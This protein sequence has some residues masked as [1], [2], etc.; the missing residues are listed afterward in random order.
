MDIKAEIYSIIE[1][2]DKT[3]VFTSETIARNTLLSYIK[4]NKGKAVFKDRFISFDHFA[5]SL[6]D[7]KGLRRVSETERRAFVSSFLK[8][9]GLGYLSYFANSKY[10]ESFASFTRYISRILPYFPDTEKENLSFLDRQMV[11][12]IEK[13]RP[14]YQEYLKERG[15]YEENYLEKDLDRIEENKIVFVYPESFTSSFCPVV[16]KSGKV[17]VINMPPNPKPLPLHEYKN[18]IS[19]IR[20]VMRKIEKDLKE[21]SP[22]EI[23]ITSSSL[24]TYRPYME[25]EAKKRDIPLLFTSSLPLSSYPEGKILS[26]FMEL[27][28]NNWNLET[29]KRLVSDPSFPFKER[30]TLIQILHFGIDMKLEGG[31]FSNWISA[32]NREKD[33]KKYGDINKAKELFIS[34]HKSINSIVKAS[35]SLDTEFRIRNF[36]SIFLSEGE[37]NEKDDRILGSIFEILEGLKELEDKEIYKIFLSILKDTFYVENSDDKGRIKVYS[38]PA[39]AGLY[40][41][42]H[43]IMGLDDK[44]TSLLVDDYPFSSSPD[45]PE[46]LDT[47]KSFLSLYSN[48]SFSDSY[49]SGTTEGYEGSRLLPTLFLDS[50]VKEEIIESDSYEREMS[51]KGEEIKCTLSQKESHENAKKTVFKEREDLVKIQDITSSERSYSVSE[52]KSWDNCPYKGYAQSIL[53]LK[54]MEYQCEMEDHFEKGNILHETIE[55]S[56]EEKKRLIDIDLETLKKYLLESV[57]NSRKKGKIPDEAVESHMYSSIL[58]SLSSFEKSSGID[59]Y[60]KGELV[61]NEVSFSDHPLSENVFLKGRVD[62]LLKDEEGKWYILDYKLRGDADWSKDNLDEMSLQVILYYMLLTS[63]TANSEIKEEDIIVES[64]GFYSLSDKKFRVVWPQYKKTGFT[65]SSVLDNA[66]ERI[67]KII[68]YMKSGEIRIESSEDNCKN[69]DYKRLCRG[70]FVA[71]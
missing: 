33:N 53:K 24:D 26:L 16:I 48:P 3:L 40:I 61:K 9:H 22:E 35:K 25:E 21:Y 23:A 42:K 45:K 29:Y 39:S 67:N 8:S 47:G 59:V 58:N 5:L 64:G 10:K 63:P 37:W 44:S 4:D 27:D 11:S 50:T 68:E 56:L 46:A 70:R 71:K 6:A 54:K 41:K 57:E 20:G 60:G 36:R 1:N 18:A 65:L 66:N 34:L 49:I 15:L 17:Q 38:Y 30:E 2:T 14:E 52:I 51:G 13:I 12:D 28:R 62:T 19:E 31:G 43:Y 55:N 69:C 32:F 7:T